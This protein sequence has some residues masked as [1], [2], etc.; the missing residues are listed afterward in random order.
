[1]KR[2]PLIDSVTIPDCEGRG[3]IKIEPDLHDDFWI[4]VHHDG[5][6]ARARSFP[7]PGDSLPRYFLD[8]SKDWKGWTGIR[9]WESAGFRMW[10][11]HDGRAHVHL[12]I[13]L[14]PYSKPESWVLKAHLYVAPGELEGIALELREAFE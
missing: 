12:E 9:L 6:T 13:E 8:L 10:A 2:E 5:A 11:S 7:Q 3:F 14:T 4:T 1:V